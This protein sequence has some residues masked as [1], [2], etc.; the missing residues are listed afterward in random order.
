[1]PLRM[2]RRQEPGG[3]DGGLIPLVA[4]VEGGEWDRSLF[5]QRACLRLVGEDLEEPGLHRGAALEATD[6][7]DDRHPGLLNDF[8][9]DGGVLDE[10]DRQPEQRG[11][12]GIDQPRKCRLVAG[13]EPVDQFR[14]RLADQSLA[15][16]KWS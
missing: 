13:A 9:S 11:A 7:R 6:A 3:V 14:V 2:T 4:S 16:Q 15:D 8:F 1:G 10:R 5:A 12:V